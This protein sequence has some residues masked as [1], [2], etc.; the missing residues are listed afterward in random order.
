MSPPLRVLIIGAHPDDAEFHAGGLMVYLHRAGAALAVTCLTDGAAGH[1][2]LGREALA[3]RRRT[4]AEEAARQVG[5]RLS[6]WPEADGELEPSVPLRR[7][8][9]AEI[10]R[11]RPDVL[12]TH[13]GEDYHPDHRAT[14][15]LVQDACYLLRVPNVVPE[16]PPL[17]HDPIVLGMYDG[18]RRPAPFRADWVLD[19][20]PVFEC[21]VT[22]LSAHESQV[23]EWLPH[24]S[25]VSVGT[26]RRA[27][28]A[29]FYGRRPAAVARRCGPPGARYAEAFELSEYGRQLKVDE[30]A[31]YF[32][33]H[34]Q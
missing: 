12:I 30:L 28:L 8:L 7:R 4:E 25:G 20:G 29:E 18:F 14:A 24:M 6:I 19:I 16:V 34:L 2:A 22:L 32:A 27:W 21:V 31:R 23:F 9:I 26:D 1:P 13:R 17:D 11:F 10:R 3:R 15:R 33:A 5:A